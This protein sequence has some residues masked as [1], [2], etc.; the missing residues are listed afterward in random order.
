LRA[1]Q[2]Q[3]I[4]QHDANTRADHRRVPDVA[5]TRRQAL[6][7][8]AT[9]QRAMAAAAQPPP[10]APA[11]A[12]KTL[13]IAPTPAATAASTYKP[14]ADLGAARR[15]AFMGAADTA[16]G[17]NE[18]RKLLAAEAGIAD[19]DRNK[20]KVAQLE[21][22]AMKRREGANWAAPLGPQVADALKPQGDL[23]AFT[24]PAAEGIAQ[25]AGVNFD[26]SKM[27]QVDWDPQA[28]AGIADGSFGRDF[29]VPATGAPL[30]RD[31]AA[32][33]AEGASNWL[34]G[35]TSKLL[36]DEVTS[37]AYRQPVNLMDKPLVI[38][39]KS[40]M[41]VDPSA[42]IAAFQQAGQPAPI[43]IK[44]AAMLAA[45]DG[46]LIGGKRARKMANLGFLDPARL[47]ELQTPFRPA[48]AGSPR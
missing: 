29:A 35:F 8:Q 20:Y 33:T 27:M 12:G 19:G 38:G 5:A 43:D 7:Q 36:Q 3:A 9:P 42:T 18:V 34:S 22:M 6:V 23:S 44:T 31:V 48:V 1:Q 39:S 4:R 30:T 2:N 40:T 13:A 45:T 26:A 24:N 37:G 11:P 46:G 28:V 16:T 17:M 25:K 47:P 21:E 32:V 15:A 14:V 41:A 10:A